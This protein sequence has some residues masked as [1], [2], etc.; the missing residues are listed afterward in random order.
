MQSQCFM[1]LQQF[2]P[3]QFLVLQRERVFLH[4]VQLQFSWPYGWKGIGEGRSRY[5]QFYCLNQV[6]LAD[7][8]IIKKQFTSIFQKCS[9]ISVQSY[10]VQMY[11][12]RRN[13]FAFIRFISGYYSR[14]FS[15]L[16]FISV[17]QF[18]L[19]YFSSILL[20]GTRF[21]QNIIRMFHKPGSCYFLSSFKPYH[22]K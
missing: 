5:F 20:S 9:I 12:W 17:A 10:C 8:Q 16:D 15:I 6:I 14:V 1:F 3:V 4:V 18:E 21:Y 13:S 11:R 7:Y 19:Y 2:S 22:Q